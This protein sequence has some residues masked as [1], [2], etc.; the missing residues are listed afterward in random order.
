V[1]GRCMHVAVPGA[2]QAGV[3]HGVGASSARQRGGL[4]HGEWRH[5]REGRRAGQPDAG[6]RPRRVGFP[7]AAVPAVGF[8]GAAR[9]PPP[10]RI[11][12][13]DRL[14]AGPVRPGSAAT[15]LVLRLGPTLR[16]LAG[17]PSGPGEPLARLGCARV[18]CRASPIYV[19]ARSFPR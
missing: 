5:V 2:P 8:L 15:S 14:S 10:A 3:A 16:A 12:R 6:R 7:I 17:W 1:P 13:R 11:P 9:P 19:T 18:A 4:E